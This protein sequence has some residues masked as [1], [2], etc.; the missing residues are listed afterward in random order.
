MKQN[1]LII[2]FL[3]FGITLY[4]QNEIDALR[5]SRINYYGSAKFNSMAG[6]FGAVGADFSATSQNPAGMGFY[7]SSE[8]SISPLFQNATTSSNFMGKTNKD[9]RGTMYLGNLGFV[10]AFSTPSPSSAMKYFQFGIGINTINTFNNRML[11][12]GINTENSL[13]N[14]YVDNLN[15]S[16]TFPTDS[17]Y[18]V[19]EDKFST[20]QALDVDLISLGWVVIGND[21][22]KR[23]VI[24]R[25]NQGLEQRKSA[26]SKGSVQETNFAFSTN[27]LDKIYIGTTISLTNINYSETSIYTENELEDQPIPFFNQMKRYE[28]LRTN[29][30]GINM[31]IGVIYKPIEPL[32]IGLALHTPTAYFEMNDQW[33]SKMSAKYDN[34]NE[35]VSSNPRGEFDYRLTTPMRFIGSL[36]YVIG[37]HG[38]ISADYENVDYSKAKLRSDTYDFMNENENISTYLKSAH[39]FRI[40]GEFKYNIFGV[41]AGFGYYGSPYANETKLGSRYTYTFGVGVRERSYFIDLAYQIQKM[42]EEYYLYSIA[43][44]A[45]NKYSANNIQ[46]TLGVRF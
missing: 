46:L 27:L 34:G 37:N 1:I 5:Y 20:T 28:T 21:T 24:D 16:L 36:A 11:V 42:E 26:E 33:S 22:V 8:L 45:N 32:R 2:I 25:T 14:Q 10:W 43:P 38:M 3:V 17:T 29:G 35:L 44:V 39:N 4:A 18:K 41:R 30:S 19:N 23:L 7:R 15:S 13:L 9:N 40:G 31:K 6:A 12:K